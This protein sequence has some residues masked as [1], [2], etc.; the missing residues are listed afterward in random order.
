MHYVFFSIN[1]DLVFILN[2]TRKAYVLTS[3]PLGHPSKT[4]KY[5]LQLFY[6][7]CDVMIA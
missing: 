5:N 6:Y 4:N 1:K 7:Q 2:R 3:E